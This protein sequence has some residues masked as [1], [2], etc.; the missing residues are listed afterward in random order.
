MSDVVL[1]SDNEI[2]SMNI[3]TPT[4]PNED[5]K[6]KID[7]KEN[8]WRNKNN[9]QVTRETFLAVLAN[10]RSGA[11]KL[12]FFHFIKFKNSLYSK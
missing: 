6:R 8:N 3:L 11:Q 4:Q 2:I 5:I 1:V 12:Y 7:L 10:L 9:D